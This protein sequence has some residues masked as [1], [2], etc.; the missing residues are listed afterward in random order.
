VFVSGAGNACARDVIIGDAESRRWKT[1]IICEDQQQNWRC[2]WW[3]LYSKE[4]CW[5]AVTDVAARAC[6]GQKG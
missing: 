3:S 4:S 2:W 6:F 5:N 1:R